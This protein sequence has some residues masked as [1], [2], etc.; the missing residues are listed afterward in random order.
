VNFGTFRRI[1]ILKIY[2]KKIRRRSR[3]CSPQRGMI[4]QE[5]LNS[6]KRPSSKHPPIKSAYQCSGIY[7]AVEF[8]VCLIQKTGQ[9][10]SNNNERAM[11]F[12]KVEV[13]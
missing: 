6:E 2:R 10:L 5:K 4:P 1:E 13:K 7:I 11:S 8:V 12:M 9:I 3:C